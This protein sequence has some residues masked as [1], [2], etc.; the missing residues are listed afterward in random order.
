MG[1]N[2]GRIRIGKWLHVEG[3]KL[4]V[5][6]VTWMDGDVVV[7]ENGVT[8]NSKRLVKVPIVESVM[9][10]ATTQEVAHQGRDQRE[11]KTLVK[12]VLA[13]KVLTNMLLGKEVGILGLQEAVVVGLV[14]DVV[15][16][17]VALVVLE[18]VVVVVLV[19]AVLVVLEG[20]VVV[21]EAVVVVV[22]VF[23][24]VLEA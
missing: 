2:Y 10:R 12:K 13:N 6:E 1:F 7:P 9:V 8:T 22:E 21:V 17:V 16:V 3:G 5:L 19:E 23:M 11:T 4:N 15:M 20:V 14:E 18:V 24:V